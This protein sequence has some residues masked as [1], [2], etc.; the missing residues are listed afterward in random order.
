MGAT[1]PWYD[2]YHSAPN[3]QNAI[4]WARQWVGKGGF[5]RKCLSLIRQAWGAPG[6]GGTAEAAWQRELQVGRLRQDGSAPPIGAPVWFSGGASGHVAIVSKYVNGEPW[7]ITTDYPVMGKVGEVPLKQLQKAWPSEKYVGWSSGINGKTVLSGA[8][9]NAPKGV[10]GTVD[11]VEG[12][13]TNTTTYSTNSNGGSVANY[14]A[15][16]TA[17]AEDVRAYV[18]ANFGLTEAVLA[19][20]KSGGKNLRWAFN[21]IVSHKITDEYRAAN[22]LA[23]T[24]W[25]KK[26]G[27][28][29]TKKLAEEKNGPGSFGRAVDSQVSTI[30]DRAAALGITLDDATLRKIAR[31][32]YIYSLN[33]SQIIDK[34]IQSG[35][36]T[37]GGGTVGQAMDSL[38][39][40][41]YQSGLKIS[42]KDAQ[43]W[44]NAIAAGDKTPQDYMKLMREQ[45]AARYSV[46]G[47]QIRAGQ[48]LSDLTSAY[49]QK[50][51]DLLEVDPSAIEWDDPLFKDGKAFTA[52]DPKTG[53]P[54]MKT[55]WDFEKD[56]KNDSRWQYTR[57]AHESYVGKAQ[58]LLQRFGMVA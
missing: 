57:N 23:Q 44:G 11:P 33:D 30:K 37:T 5:Q 58:Q 32:S 6:L 8:A 27:V 40:F 56:I 43:L 19:L 34:M 46:F 36:S 35:A 39:D 25:F 9:L 12:T 50:A 4:A 51:A 15:A 42:D 24:S 16:P 10:T 3:V 52:V 20:D 38:K 53:Q 1:D 17:S 13:S 45:S 48:N 49:R 28:E 29:V 7:I 31:D 54:A 41:A 26:Y 21:Y 22:I 14:N 47:D 18:E 55:L 2:D